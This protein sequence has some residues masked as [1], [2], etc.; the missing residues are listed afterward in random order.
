MQ[1]PGQL[2]LNVSARNQRTLLKCK[3]PF[4]WSR[5]KMHKTN[6]K[7]RKQTPGFEFGSQQ[8][9]GWEVTIRGVEIKLRHPQY[10]QYQISGDF[11]KWMAVS[12]TCRWKQDH[13]WFPGDPAPCSAQEPF[14]RR[15]PWSPNCAQ[16]S[17]QRWVSYM[18][19]A[20]ASIKDVQRLPPALIQGKASY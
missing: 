14:D 10:F 11:Y 16:L 15:N 3:N 8:C 17:V 19:L 18:A 4:F 13:M 6:P 12:R 2:N 1:T 5:Q 7:E 20:P 9:S